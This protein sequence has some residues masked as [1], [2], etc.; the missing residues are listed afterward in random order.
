MDLWSCLIFHTGMLASSRWSKTGPVMFSICW[1]GTNH[2]RLSPGFCLTVSR[3]KARGTTEEH[4]LYSSV[5]T[6]YFMWT[7]QDFAEVYQRILLEN[8]SLVEKAWNA[9][10]HH[11]SSFPL[12]HIFQFWQISNVTFSK[13]FSQ[14]PHPSI[15]PWRIYF[16]LHCIAIIYLYFS[17]PLDCKLFKGEQALHLIVYTI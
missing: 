4:L 17:L 1:L 16:I 14:Y 3:A 8:K 11:L 7:K 10:T 15:C 5:S 6:V 2:Q 13:G 12:P 9:F